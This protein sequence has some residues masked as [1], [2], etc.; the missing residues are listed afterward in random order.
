MFAIPTRVGVFL[1]LGSERK[2][3]SHGGLFS[4]QLAW[5]GHGHS[6]TNQDQEVDLGTG[7]ESNVIC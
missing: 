5:A 3:P 1:S 4:Q 6:E 7:I 2:V